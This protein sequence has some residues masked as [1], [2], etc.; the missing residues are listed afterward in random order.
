MT[1]NDRALN[2][3]NEY[4]SLINHYS[5]E[6]K[7]VVN[8]SLRQIASCI[9]QLQTKT[10]IGAALEV[11]FWFNE[12]EHLSAMMATDESKTY[13]ITKSDEG[14]LVFTELADRTAFYQKS[15]SP[16]PDLKISTTGYGPKQETFS[17]Q[18]RKQKDTKPIVELVQRTVT[19][20]RLLAMKAD[21]IESSGGGITN[22]IISDLSKDTPLDV[23]YDKAK[24]ST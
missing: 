2:Y 1:L 18:F 9:T 6:Q 16:T 8:D 13:E 14:N 5:D 7:H 15:G 19:A 3:L 23:V 11:R 17:A 22:R 10:H 24:N 21:F 4:S 12:T 20:S